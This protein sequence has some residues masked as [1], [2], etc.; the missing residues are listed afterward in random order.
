MANDSESSADADMSVARFFD[1]RAAYM[2]FSTAT[3]EKPVVAARVGEELDEVQPGP[4][5]LKVRL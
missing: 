3:N 4:R 5:A 1:T 2:M